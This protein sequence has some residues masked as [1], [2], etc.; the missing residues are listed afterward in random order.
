MVR[1]H[2][3]CLDTHAVVWIVGGLSEKLGTEARALIDHARLL[4]SP[5]VRLELQFLYEVGRV[6]APADEAVRVLEH[7]LD[8]RIAD[9]PFDRVVSVALSESWTRDPF[10]RLI[11][12]HARLLGATL[13]TRD[14]RMAAAYADTR[15]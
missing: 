14:R 4:I 1:T 15:W 8:V 13:V 9:E 12:A 2:P 10:D 5:A 11:V 6:S 3:V 7:A